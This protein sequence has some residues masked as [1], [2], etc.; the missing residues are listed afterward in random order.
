MPKASAANDQ[1]LAALA[2]SGIGDR[3]QAR[4][5]ANAALKLAPNRDVRTT[6]AFAIARAGDTAGADKLAA[7][8]DKTYPL[9]TLVQR[10]WLPTIRAAVA[11][12]RQDPN[13]A[14]ELLRAANAIGRSANGNLNPVYARGESYLKLHNGEA[15]AA[16]FQKF[17][18]HR[19]VVFD[20]VEAAIQS[21][22]SRTSFV[23]LW[24]FGEFGFGR[25][26]DGKI[27][28]G[29]FP[30][31]KQLPIGGFGFGG[32]SLHGVGAGQSQPG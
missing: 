21:G 5:E 6:A 4:S 13:K 18:D 7:E 17:I 12:E 10:Y 30:N 9:D 2:R 26:E 22:K 15:V 28:V 25:V 11:L 14:I 3:E 16:V 23:L 24:Q 1:A 19:G 27:G 29:V 20:N 31:G 32:V 8:L